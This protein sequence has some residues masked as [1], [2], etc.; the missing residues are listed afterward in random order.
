MDIAQKTG[1]CLGILCSITTAAAE[2][3]FPRVVLDDSY[4]AYERDVGDI[5]GDGLSDVAA[6]GDGGSTI[7]WFHAPDWT[8]QTLYTLTGTYRYTRADDFKVADI[9][10]DGDLDLVVRLG[11]GPSDEGEGRAAWIENLGSGTGWVTR[12]IGTSPSYVKDIAVGDLDRDDRPDIV[13]REDSQT[14]IW[15]QEINGWTEVTL[16]HAAH[17]GM[18]LGD[19]DM[20]GD[21]DVV[22]NGFWFTTPN[23]PADCRSAAH[24]TNRT[25]DTQW[26]TQT[27]DWTANSCKVA[28]GDIDGDGSNDVV[29]S[30]SERAGHPVTW[31]KQAGAAWTAHIV[32]NVD[33]AHNLQAYDADL[34]GDIDILTGGMTQSSQKGLQLLLNAG[35]GTAWTPFIIQTDGSYSAELGDIDNDGDLDI[36]GIVNWNSAPSYIYRNNS[37]GPPSLDF[38]RYI[39]VSAS[40]VRTFGLDFIDADGDDDL[41][42]ASGP[43]LYLNPGGNMTST[44]SQIEAA[45]GRHLFMAMEVDGDSFADALALE[46]N[47]GQNRIDLYWHEAGSTQ[48][49]NWEQVVRFGDVPRSDHAEGFQGSRLAQIENGGPSEVVISSLQGIYYFNLP[50]H[51]ATGSWPR[52][53]VAANDSD[54]GIGVMDLDGDLDLD[55]TFTSGGSKQVK[56]ARN[57]GNGTG[58]WTV[59]TIGAFSEADWPDRCAAADVNGDGRPD[60]VVTEENSGAS[61]DAMAC[62][63]EQP[64][65]S[66]TNAGWTRHLITTRYTMN[67]LDAGDVDRDGDVDLVLAEHRGTKIISVFANDGLG[68]F[69]EYPVGAGHENHLGGK[70]ADLDGDGDLDLAGIAYDDFTQLH[71]WRNDS[72]S[73]IPTVT[74]P[75]IAPNGGVFDEPLTAALACG[76]TGA[77]IWYSLDGSTP[78]NSVPSLLYT[79]AVIPIATSLVIRARGFKNELAPSAIASATFTGPQVK[80]PEISPA[81]GAFEG[82]A[83]VTLACTTTGTLIRFTTTGADPDTSSDVYAGPFNL[84]ND[85]TVKA[86]AFRAGLA[87]SPVA[88]ASFTRFDGGP[89]AYWRLDERL[90]GLAMDA[91]GHAHTGAVSGAEWIVGHLDNALSF[92]G[93]DDHVACGAWDIAGE[94]L[95]IAAWIRVASPYLDNDS[96]ILSKALGSSEQDHYWML[97]LTLVGGEPRLRF[98]LKTGGTTATLIAG[99]GSISL[100]AWHHAAAVYDGSALRLYLDGLPV[101]NQAASGS[102]SANPGADIFIGANPP[103]AYAPFKG[104]LDDV[105]VYDLALSLSEIQA[106]RDAQPPPLQPGIRALTPSGGDGWTLDISSPPGHYQI[107]QAASN[108]MEN[109]WRDIATNSAAGENLIMEHTHT[110]PQGF[111]R[112]L[113]N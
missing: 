8:R 1:C 35:G 53:F 52:V 72:P 86:R 42:I 5:D 93:L 22:L 49:T 62:W 2:L 4:I 47:A 63:W 33:Y 111:Y 38:W 32:T 31:Y 25:I 30:Q 68:V 85:T 40:H 44:W 24:Y 3:N 99:S 98:R 88:S 76:T 100:D 81:G 102:M 18:E 108:L 106:I 67:N 11:A 57:P 109:T 92:D 9:D 75:T 34:D 45:P 70:L 27:G 60:I 112:L 77:E 113:Q 54:E 6:T 89:R 95:T 56:W 58:D 51:P 55:I 105:R 73:G 20:D 96:R 83:T 23:S 43:Y 29:F 110:P 71:V 12:I 66:P 15:L 59:F 16:S 14:Q 84:T 21:V 26:F 39:Q 37:G 101:G 48:A 91:G 10:S 61:P 94:A 90:G 104:L 13:L 103:D 74:R 36:A 17:E 69:T 80:T 87:D 50:V 107:L 7:E 46:D 82:T 78:S 65:S 79:N 41:D 28:V 19:L 97:S 64:A